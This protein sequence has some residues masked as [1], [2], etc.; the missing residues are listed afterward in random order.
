M[1]NII[2]LLTSKKY[3]VEIGNLD[4][5]NDFCVDDLPSNTCDQVSFHKLHISMAYHLSVFS[6]PNWSV[7]SLFE[8]VLLSEQLDRKANTNNPVC[9][10]H[11]SRKRT[12]EQKQLIDRKSP[13]RNTIRHKNSREKT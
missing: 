1:L 8:R 7:F 3:A 4:T 5:N 10:T 11:S 6:F 12:M 13:A 9:I 2:S